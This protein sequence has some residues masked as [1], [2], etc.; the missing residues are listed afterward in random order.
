MGE[1]GLPHEGRLACVGYGHAKACGSSSHDHRVLSGVLLPHPYGIIDTDAFN[2]V[3]Y[4][5][6]HAAL[7]LCAVLP[8]G[9]N[10]SSY[11]PDPTVNWDSE[12]PTAEKICWVLLSATSGQFGGKP[13]LTAE[14]GV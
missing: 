12:P 10:P 3:N 7:P 9:T 1:E 5:L 6:L 11:V 13:Q 8:T 4:G 2:A 14:P